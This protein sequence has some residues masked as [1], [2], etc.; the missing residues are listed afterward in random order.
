M[1]RMRAG[2]ALAM[3][4]LSSMAGAQV[5]AA[6]PAGTLAPA[7]KVAPAAKASAQPTP[8]AARV[9][10]IAVLN[11][12]SGRVTRLSARPG[13]VLRHEALTIA[14]R[15]CDKSAPW[16]RPGLTGA[17]LQIDE[18]RINA[19]PSRIFSGW[20]FAESPS[21]NAVESARYDVWLTSCA[22]SF[23]ETGPDTVVAGRAPAQSAPKPAGASSA[24][25]S[26]SS[27]PK[28]AVADTAADSRA[29]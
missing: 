17:F 15:A 14:V 12:D 25:A 23:P 11:K 27:A 28:S 18:Q 7:A 20:L 3:L 10:G 4:G 26:T 8:M 13:Q 6:E 19:R 22:M 16:V 1:I 5:P 29:R 2:L 24:P 9:A 21:L